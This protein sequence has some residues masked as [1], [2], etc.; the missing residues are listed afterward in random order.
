MASPEG[1][2]AVSRGF[3]EITGA[4]G[5]GSLWLLTLFLVLDAAA[6]VY[7]V[8]E[9]SATSASWSAFVAVPMI[10]ASFVAGVISMALG[11]EI[12]GALTRSRTTEAERLAMVIDRDRKLLSDAY[13]QFALRRS[14]LDGAMPALVALSVAVALEGLVFGLATLGTVL[15]AASL[16]A[17][18]A[19]FI[20]AHR[21]ET[22]F[23]AM[24]GALER[25]QRATLA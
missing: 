13:Q 2:A 10:V 20:L 16:V 18:A 14:V 15:A 25:T 5:V 19:A 3:S 22:E 1:L 23:D 9:A 17:A 12:R 4:F 11:A 8:V 7:A 24:L 21:L 6:N